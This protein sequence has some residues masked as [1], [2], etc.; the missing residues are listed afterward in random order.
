[1][2]K[3]NCQKSKS[4]IAISVDRKSTMTIRVDLKSTMTIRADI[5]STMTISVNIKS[6]HTQHRLTT[7]F[8]YPILVDHCLFI[9]RRLNWGGEDQ[10]PFINTMLSRSRHK[11]VFSGAWL[12]YYATLGR[13]RPRH[14]FFWAAQNPSLGFL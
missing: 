6:F 5:K 3:R 7:V 1:M 2:Q 14:G 8:L 11:Y 4:T 10:M 13:E 9:I 12:L